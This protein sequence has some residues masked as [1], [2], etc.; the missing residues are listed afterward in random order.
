MVSE[1]T[2]EIIDKRLM[3]SNL[4]ISGKVEESFCLVWYLSTSYY[5][6]AFKYPSFCV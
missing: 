6:V 1:N 4:L 5:L 3:S 2:K